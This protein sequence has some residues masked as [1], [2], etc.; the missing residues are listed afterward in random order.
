MKPL[1]GGLGGWGEGGGGGLPHGVGDE[2]D[3]DGAVV[4]RPG[5]V[6]VLLAEVH[7]LF[8]QPGL[9]ELSSHGVEEMGLPFQESGGALCQLAFGLISGVD[10]RRD[11][12][13]GKVV[14][15]GLLEMFGKI[16]KRIVVA[17]MSS[18]FA[19]KVE[20]CGHPT[21][22]PWMKQSSRMRFILTDLMCL[23]LILVIRGK[24]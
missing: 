24:W 5:C 19:L 8:L 6:E 15:D 4:G 3:A 16:A 23:I 7:D 20:A 13:I 9:D 2:D 18:T 12:V 22:N 17:L 10:D 14:C 21:L 1:G 11:L